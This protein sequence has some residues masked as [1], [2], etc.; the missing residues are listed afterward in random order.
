MAE[1]LLN[2]PEVNPEFDQMG[3]V[4][5]SQSSDRRPFVHSTFSKG[6]F[7]G[8]LNIIVRC[9]SCGDRKVVVTSTPGRREDPVWIAVCFVPVS[10]FGARPAR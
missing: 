3:G 1:I 8:N 6:R 9:K 10:E 4:R 7:E 2:E 5:M